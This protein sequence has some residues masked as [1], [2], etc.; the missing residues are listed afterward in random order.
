MRR[1]HNLTVVALLLLAASVPGILNVVAKDHV[2]STE[3][4]IAWISVTVFVAAVI[5]LVTLAGIRL[6]RFAK[7]S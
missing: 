5:T 1:P 6:R 7:L 3:G 4:V 2:S